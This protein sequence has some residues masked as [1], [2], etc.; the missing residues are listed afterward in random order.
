MVRLRALETVQEQETRRKSNCLQMMQGRISESSEDRE[1]RLEYYKSAA[2]CTLGSMSVT[3]Q[4]SS[5]MKL[6]GETP[7]FLLQ[8][9][10]GAFACVKEST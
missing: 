5:A 8:W 10:E 1:Q 4:F 7:G 6:N 3:C 9:W 2:S